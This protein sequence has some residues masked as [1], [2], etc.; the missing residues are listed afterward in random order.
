[1][2]ITVKELDELIKSELIKSNIG[3]S[4][5]DIAFIS[6]ID[7][8][9]T[10]A[11]IAECINVILEGNSINKYKIPVL[12]KSLYFILK[13]IADIKGVNLIKVLEFFL[14]CIIEANILPL[15]ELEKIVLIEIMYSSI[16]LLSETVPVVKKSKLFSCFIK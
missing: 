1:M 10:L 14:V 6:C 15:N 9:T 4:D 8:S 3:L 12:A 7:S 16:Y 11:S 5:A 2:P 13:N